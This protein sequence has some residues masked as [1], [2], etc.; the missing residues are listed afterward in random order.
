MPFSQEVCRRFSSELAGAPALNLHGDA[1]VEQ[2]AVTDLGRGLTDFDDSSTGPA[3][4]DLVRLGTSMHLAAAQQGF[5]EASAS[6]L[7]ELLRGYRT[8]LEDPATEVAEPALAQRKR[9][10]FRHD[11]EGFFTFVESVME[12]MTDAEVDDLSAALG[13]YF[14]AMTRDHPELG[15]E[16]FSVSQMGLLRQGIGSALD[17][18]FLVRLRGPSEDPLDD[19]VLE[20]KQVRDITAIDCIR[21]VSGEDPLRV[22]VGHARI[23][24]EP[25]RF[26]GY[27]RLRE[28]NFWVHAW[29]ENYSEL[30]VEELTSAEELAEVAFDAGVQLGRGHTTEIAGPVEQQLRHDVARLVERD[31]EKIQASCRE[32]AKEVTD[33]WERFAAVAGE[34]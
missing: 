1:H 22:L 10:K 26:L 12:P 32:L 31:A 21:V 3:T 6:L 19:V 33:A 15:R 16:F 34:G 27:A 7:D 25:F 2:Y 11:S 13:D 18:K 20:V 8:A 29:V 30:D 24:N 5:G 17:L 9:E 14:E 4:I 23:A 28:H